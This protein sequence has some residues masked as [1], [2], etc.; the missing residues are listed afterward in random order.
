MGLV[1][2]MNLLEVIQVGVSM[3]EGKNLE[4]TCH[5]EIS[6]IVQIMV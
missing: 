2:E 5:L 6:E 3:K 4:E 1:K